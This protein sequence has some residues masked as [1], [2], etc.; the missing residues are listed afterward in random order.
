[1]ANPEPSFADVLVMAHATS[2]GTMRLKARMMVHSMDRIRGLASTLDCSCNSRSSSPDWLLM[3]GGWYGFFASTRG[4]VGGFWGDGNWEFGRVPGSM[5]HLSEGSDDRMEAR[6][7]LSL[8][9]SR[10]ATIT[11]KYDNGHKKSSFGF[12]AKLLEFSAT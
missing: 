3:R 9:G 8:R 7:G 5:A 4:L 10:V 11:V 6:V 2:A 12:S 1:M